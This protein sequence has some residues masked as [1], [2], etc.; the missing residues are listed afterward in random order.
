MDSAGKRIDG[1]RIIFFDGV[2]TL[3]NKGVDFIIKKDKKNAF[4]FASLQS[5]LFSK[6]AEQ[7]NLRQLDY[8][9]LYDRG[10]LYTKSRA[11]L[12]IARII[13]GFYSLFYAFIIIPGFIRNAVY[14]KIAKNRYKWFGKKNTCRIPTKDERS[15]FLE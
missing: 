3:C 9:V 6:V 13:G 11:V 2:C 4:Y 15:R 10:K 8:V 5:D 14:Q 12:E 1:K 7:N